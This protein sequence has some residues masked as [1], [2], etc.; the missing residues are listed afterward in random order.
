MLVRGGYLDPGDDLRNAG[1]YGIYWS[2]VSHISNY[3]YD[4]DFDSGGVSPSSYGY[5]YRGYSIRCVALGG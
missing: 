2:S 3:A 5:R 1:Y 4:L